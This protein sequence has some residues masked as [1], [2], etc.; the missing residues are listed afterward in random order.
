MIFE[1]MVEIG[2][3]QGDFQ[4]EV[5]LERYDSDP[6]FRKEEAEICQWWRGFMLP[7]NCPP[8]FGDPAHGMAIILCDP[9][10]ILF[11]TLRWAGHEMQYTVLCADKYPDFRHELRIDG[12][13][14]YTN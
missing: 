1:A 13:L 11:P 14:V 12:S 3:L 6:Y 2:N 10:S 4:V 5:F 7:E 9:V 8:G